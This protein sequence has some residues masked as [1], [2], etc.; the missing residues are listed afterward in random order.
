MY[1]YAC[2]CVFI[3]VRRWEATVTTSKYYRGIRRDR[4]R[5]ITTF[6]R[7]ADNPARFE[8]GILPNSSQGCYRYGSLNSN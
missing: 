1:V 2:M 6:I 7:L 4:Q 3:Y 8:M 5:E